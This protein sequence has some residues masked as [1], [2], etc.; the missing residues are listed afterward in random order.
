MLFVSIDVD[1][2]RG[3]KSYSLLYQILHVC[4][5]CVSE[6]LIMINISYCFVFF[7][8]SNSFVLLLQDLVS[9]CWKVFSSVWH[10]HLVNILQVNLGMLQSTLSK[11]QPPNTPAVLQSILLKERKIFV[12]NS[13]SI[14]KLFNMIQIPDASWVNWCNIILVWHKVSRSLYHLGLDWSTLGFGVMS[15]I[16]ILLLVMNKKSEM[17]NIASVFIS[18]QIINDWISLSNKLG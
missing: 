8:G 7:C 12:R 15:Q 3:C 18:L 5:S 4:M 9:S 11:M 16:M 10:Y 14:R 1:L 17:R 13:H 2:N 6:L